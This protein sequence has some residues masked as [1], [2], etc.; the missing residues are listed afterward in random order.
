MGHEQVDRKHRL[1]T[2]G[3]GAS[4]VVIPAFI[5]LLAGGGTYLVRKNLQLKE[6]NEDL[7]RPAFGPRAGLLVAGVPAPSL[8]GDS[9]QYWGS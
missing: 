8:A 7:T 5:S 3:K 2:L 9:F 4:E 6:Q 1:E